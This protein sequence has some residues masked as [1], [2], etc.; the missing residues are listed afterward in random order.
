ME[1]NKSNLYGGFDENEKERIYVMSCLPVLPI[2]DAVIAP[3]TTGI[4]SVQR[5]TSMKALMASQNMDTENKVFVTAQKS[6]CDYPESD[7]LYEIG[8]ICDVEYI[9]NSEGRKI[10]VKLSGQKLAIAQI[11]SQGEM[12]VATVNELNTI[13]TSNHAESIAIRKLIMDTLGQ[14]GIYSPNEIGNMKDEI[15]DFESLE[16]VVNH[17]C[18]NLNL[19][20]KSKQELLETVDLKKKCEILIKMLKEKIECMKTTSKITERVKNS[21]DKSNRENLLRNQ[22]AAIDKELGEGDDCEV[23]ELRKNMDQQ[24]LPQDVRKKCIEE[25]DRLKGMAPMSIE[26]SMSLNY[27][28]NVLSLPWENESILNNYDTPTA[29]KI[30][31]KNHYGLEEVKDS[32]LEYLAVEKRVPNG[33]APIICFVGPPGVGKTSL[34]KSIATATGREFAKISLGG[35]CDEA[36]I[37]GHIRTYV[38]SQPGKIIAALK[39]T[40][41]KNPLILLDEID[42]I[43]SEHRGDPSAALLEVLDP[44]QNNKFV[45]NFIDMPFDLSQVMFVCTA[46]TLKI[47]PPLLDRLEIIKLSGYTEKERIKIAQKH[48]IKDQF[49]KTGLKSKEAVISTNAI[50]DIIRY[51]TKEA[52]VRSLERGLGKLCRK[53]VVELDSPNIKNNK[54]I[55]INSKNLQKYLGS[56]L[57]SSHDQESENKVG[58]VTGLAWTEYGGEILP[59]ESCFYQG[60]GKIKRTGRLGDVLSESIDAAISSVRT[61]S[62][63]DLVK[64]FNWEAN[65]FHIHL[66]DGSIAKDGPSAGIAIATSILSSILNIAVKKNVAMTGEITL[67]GNVLR[68]GGI[69]EKLLAAISSGMK[70]VILPKENKIDMMDISDDIKKKLKII[71]VS[72]INEVFEHALVKIPQNKNILGKNHINKTTSTEILS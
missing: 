22:R 29:K 24:K 6:S 16:K 63:F 71:Y 39:N 48:I 60:K 4:F 5:K 34:A 17:L 46:N 43:S 67:R 13:P 19:E 53:L 15:S 35:I 59:V 37:R 57:Y 64:K 32:I 52:G 26:K 20:L 21:M 14:Y 2:K 28:R 1:K 56:K 68:I 51:Y 12:L 55:S 42:K 47:T 58:V 61:Q 69:K 38:A 54:K 41:T 27:I 50:K 3:F 66:P 23:Q 10:Q 11:V 8:C 31:D 65:D 33:K 49:N 18:V 30:L 7:D 70:T 72:N 45:D 25:I 62:N 44:M 9:D 40:N 36:G